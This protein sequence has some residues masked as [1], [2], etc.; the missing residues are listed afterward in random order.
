MS[1]S[2]ATE[3]GW[4]VPIRR[5]LLLPE[6]AA[7]SVPPL[8]QPGPVATTTGGPGPGFTPVPLPHDKTARKRWPWRL[9]RR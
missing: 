5:P 9:D 3:G 6:I 4:P 1:S 8:S 7:P 2:N